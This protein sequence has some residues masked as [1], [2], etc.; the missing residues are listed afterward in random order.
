MRTDH[1]DTGRDRPGV[2][3][4]SATGGPK[5]SP[6]RAS[7]WRFWATAY[8]LLI[9][10]T[11]TNLPTPLYRDYE[12]R[13][14]LSPLTTT[15][16]FAAYVVVLIPSLLL[17]GPLSDAI[18]R[19]RVLI[20]SLAVAALGTVGFALASGPGWLFAS[21]A[22]QG[23]AI[24]AAAGPLTAALTELEPTGDHRRAALVSTVVT[25]GG[26]GLGPVLG[27]LLAQYGP[28]PRV[29]PFVVELMLLI[30][31]AVAIALLPDTRP[32][33]RWRPRRP[34][35]PPSVRTVFA[36][37]GTATFLAFAVI[38]LFLTLVPAY[39]ATLAHSAN[40]VLGGGVV[41]L[42]LASSAI[43]QLVAYGRPSHSPE[44]AGLPL[45]ATGLGLLA[46]AG[47]L[48][49]PLVL[50]AAVV[51]A[52]AGQG[53]V[54]LGGLAAVNASA[55]ADRRAGVLSSFYVIT[56]IGVGVP[57]IGVGFLATILDVTVAVRYF[58]GVVA[59]L[60]LALLFVLGR[61]RRRG[62]EECRSSNP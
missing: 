6:R 34:E 15:L 5:P 39:V 37:S 20:P 35:I 60:C 27:A 53:L 14:G 36:T 9:L 7:T 11:G 2:A 26:M 48:S 33:T 59:V 1:L 56:Y 62:E 21:R 24:G 41:A 40:L 4:S 3:D 30:P 51:V 12:D 18:G 44:R 17:V 28:A 46:L 22:L 38:G 32:T 43:A 55:T 61:A 58:A 47:T 50:L 31:A 10:L 8:T 29:L 42:M 49:S 23:L 52:G 16:I 19:R 25:V 13:F 54:Y 45:L 57:V